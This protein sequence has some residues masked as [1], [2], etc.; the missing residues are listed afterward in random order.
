MAHYPFSDRPDMLVFTCIHVL[1][2]GKPVTLVCHHF[3]DNAWEFLCDG[4]HTDEDA[5]VISIGELCEQ[6][7]SLALLCDLPVGGCAVRESPAHAW[8]LGRIDGEN[9][10][11]AAE[12]RM[13]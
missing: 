2:E 13:N 5:L 9:F 3:D 11:P 1:E 12:S 8:R 7:P 6:D 4:H 10:Y